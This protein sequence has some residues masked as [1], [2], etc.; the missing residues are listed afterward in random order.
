[1]VDRYADAQGNTIEENHAEVIDNLKF[2]KDT[3]TLIHDGMYQV[4]NVSPYYTKMSGLGIE[5]SGKSGTA[6]E[7]DNEAEH[8][9]FVGYAPSDNPQIAAS[10]IV[11]NGY[12]SK[13]IL[14]LYA[15][16]VCEYYGIE[17]SRNGNNDVLGN[18]KDGTA[19]PKNPDLPRT[20][21]IPASSGAN[22]D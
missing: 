7:S 15:D 11:P 17:V 3:W 18:T 4:C 12:G 21:N 13:N 9:L 8:S 20:A 14:D 1:M 19:S 22:S 16:L 2:S 10:L 5:L 6:E